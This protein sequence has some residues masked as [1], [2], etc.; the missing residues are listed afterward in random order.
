MALREN[1]QQKLEEEWTLEETK[2]TLRCFKNLK[3][4]YDRPYRHTNLPVEDC[5]RMGVSELQM[6]YRNTKEDDE[7]KTMEDTWKRK[8]RHRL[9][10]NKSPREDGENEEAEYDS[11]KE[12]V[13]EENDGKEEDDKDHMD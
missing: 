3:K 8:D 6:D 4:A 2:R 13:S 11:D 9:F 12:G 1:K 10:R 7:E 5:V